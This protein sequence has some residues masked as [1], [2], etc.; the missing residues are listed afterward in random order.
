MDVFKEVHGEIVREAEYNLKFEGDFACGVRAIKEG[1]SPLPREIQPGDLYILDIYPSFHGYHGDL[2][3]TFAASQPTNLQLQACEVVRGAL[4]LA[5]QMI[6]PGVRAQDV[7]RA[8]HDHID[9]FEG[10]RGSFRHHAGHGIGLE[11]QEAPW[12]IPGSRHVFEDGDVIALEPG[13]YAPALQGGVRLESNY[14]VRKD[15]LED[16][17]EFPYALKESADFQT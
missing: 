1:G 9:S 16:L 13:C 14:V 4:E 5:E 7:W 8:L 15:G 2:C 17:S 10:V 11:S 6:R 3:R 12:I